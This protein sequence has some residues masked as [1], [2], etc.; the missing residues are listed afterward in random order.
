MLG[1]VY[2]RE[3]R[4]NEIFSR[5]S[6]IILQDDKNN[7]KKINLTLLLWYLPKPFR[8]SLDPLKDGERSATTVVQ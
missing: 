1:S 5:P 4:A 3:I 2:A 6:T 8:C 7:V